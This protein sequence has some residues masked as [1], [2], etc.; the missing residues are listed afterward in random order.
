MNL[1]SYLNKED[2]VFEGSVEMCLLAQLYHFR[3]MLVVDMGIY[4]KQSLQDSFCY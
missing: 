1:T 3:E 4:S 2:K